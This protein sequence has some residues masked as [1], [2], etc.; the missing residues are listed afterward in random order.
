MLADDATPTGLYLW[1]NP[2]NGL[3]YDDKPDDQMDF[4]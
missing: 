4:L 2:D 3:L 1:R